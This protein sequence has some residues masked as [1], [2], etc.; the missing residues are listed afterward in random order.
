MAQLG[1]HGMI[2]MAVRKLVPARTWLM[3]GI[4]LGSILPD[5]DN[6][7]VAVATLTGGSTEGL[8]RTFTH[9]IITVAFIVLV[10]FIIGTVSKKPRW[11]N[12]GLGLG[13]GI[14][15][16]ILVDFVI[17]FN[18][19][20]VLWPLPVWINFW[21]GYTMPDWWYVLMDSLELLFI[22]TFFLVLDY[23]ARKRGTDKEYLKPLRVW[24]WVEAALF[25]VFIVL[26]FIVKMNTTII[27][28]GVYLLSLILAAGVT[29]RMRRTIE[30]I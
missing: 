8:H 22:A 17:W 12:L 3:L 19:V 7:A 15:M 6:F 18:G 26:G 30:A 5:S 25:L 28:G 4:I 9:S 14:L 27:F 2:G 16:H 20:A 24:T 23:T 10:F 13:I 1:I 11:T 21:E 29:I